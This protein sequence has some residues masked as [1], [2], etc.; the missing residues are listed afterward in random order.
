MMTKKFYYL[1]LALGLFLGMTMFTACG[2]DDDDSNGSNGTGNNP[3]TTG[4]YDEALAA[5]LWEGPVHVKGQ[6]G[7]MDGSIVE[8]DEDMPADEIN[9]V[10]LKADHTYIRYEL[11]NGSYVADGTGTW[12]LEGNKVIVTENGTKLETLTIVSLDRNTMV[13]TSDVE[14]LNINGTYLEFTIRRIQ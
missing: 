1:S 2:S 10:E 13:Y 4:T 6:K 11:E 7:Y 14:D 8:V 9:R 12:K 5:G 3:A